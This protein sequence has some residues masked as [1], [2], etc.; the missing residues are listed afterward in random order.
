MKLPWQIWL[1]IGVLY[2]LGV[3]DLALLYRYGESGTLSR[4]I[5]SAAER[6]P[7]LPFLLGV[8]AGHLLWSQAQ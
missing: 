6:Y 4:Q 1:L 3:L 5:L 8:L 7:I 2:F